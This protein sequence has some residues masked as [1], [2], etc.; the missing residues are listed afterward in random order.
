MLYLTSLSYI[1]FVPYVHFKTKHNLYLNEC[2]KCM[3]N[4]GYHAK[5]IFLINKY[6]LLYCILQYAHAGTC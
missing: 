5:K 3:A 1:D 4:L 2:I 6:Q